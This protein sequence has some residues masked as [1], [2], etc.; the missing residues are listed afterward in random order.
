MASLSHRWDIPILLALS[1]IW[2][3]SFTMIKVAIPYVTPVYLVFTR[4]AIG[5]VIMGIV[6]IMMR[7]SA[8]WPKTLRQW[9]LLLFVGVFSTALPFYFISFAEQKITSGMTAILMT[10]GPLVVIVLGH[11]FTDDEKINRGKILGIGIGFF[12]AVYLLRSG[13]SGFNQKDLLHP[14]AAIAAAICYSVGGLAAKKLTEITAEV[15]AT[16]VLVASALIMFVVL[17]VQH[18]GIS[19]DVLVP[20]LPQ[21]IW[22][23]LIWLGAVPSGLA[24][25]LRY[26]LIKRA[27]YGFVSYVGYLIPLFT[28][29]IGFVVLNEVVTMPTLFAM[30][31]ILTGLFFTR[32]AGD[33]PWS[34]TP[35]LQAFRKRLN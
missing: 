25:Y 32:S 1:L 24:F 9:G 34:V 3:S 11:F 19:M 10:T 5:A 16:M 15:I 8:T 23:S 7:S 35:K 14:L 21:N 31:I 12:A 26:F 18:G 20:T 6:L 30:A 13:L 2:A 22:L 27:G 28:I 33:V 17:M 4:C 29:A